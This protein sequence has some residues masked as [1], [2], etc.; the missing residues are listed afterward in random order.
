M[1]ETPLPKRVENSLVVNARPEQVFPL[2]ENPHSLMKWVTFLRQVQWAKGSGIGAKDRCQLEIAGMKV[3]A[4]AQVQVYEKNVRIGRES[5]EGMRMRSEIHLV[6]DGSNTRVEWAMSYR[7]PMG[8]LG[9]LMDAMIMRRAIRKGVATSLGR[10]KGLAES[11]YKPIPHVGVD[12]LRDALVSGTPPVPVD[13]RD[14]EYFARASDPVREV[15]RRPSGNADD[16]RTTSMP[17]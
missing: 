2:L 1:D 5:V 17:A 4:V 3:W 7:P 12:V 13:A 14:P 10:L 6:P 9:S 16:L 8:R 15:T 11:G